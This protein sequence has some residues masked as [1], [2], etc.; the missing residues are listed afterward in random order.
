M[1]DEIMSQ[2]GAEGF[3]LL[4]H[5]ATVAGVTAIAAALIWLVVY[6][7]WHRRTWPMI[8]E[9]SDRAN[10][11]LFLLIISIIAFFVVGAINLP[12]VIDPEGYVITQIVEKSK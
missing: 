6:F 2:L 4:A 11:Q 12:Q 5:H 9:H 1:K 3:Q 10:W 7:I 8:R